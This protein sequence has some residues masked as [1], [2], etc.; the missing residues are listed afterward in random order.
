MKRIIFFALVVLC[1]CTPKK[2]LHAPEPKNLEKLNVEVNFLPHNTI[3]FVITN[4]SDETVKIFQHYKLQIEKQN[5]EDWVPL[6]I[7]HC[8]CGAPCAKPPEYIELL[9]GKQYTKSWDM[10]ESWCGEEEIQKFIPETITI[11]I[12]PGVYRI[13][14][15]HSFSDKD[16]CLVYK[17]FNV[18]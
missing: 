3:D 1:A 18:K 14:I 5:G 7:L 17:E 15:L 16:N 11:P 13:A 9:A 8:P 10:K 4:Q 12:G 2:V 6:R